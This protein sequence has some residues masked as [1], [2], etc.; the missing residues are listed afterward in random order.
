MLDGG[1]TCFLIGCLEIPCRRAAHHSYHY[2][3]LLGDGHSTGDIT[4]H[5]VTNGTS[6]GIEATILPNLHLDAPIRGHYL[7]CRLRG[8]IVPKLI[9]D[10]VG[11]GANDS[12]GLVLAQRQ[13][14]I[15]LE[16]GDGFQG[17]PPRCSDGQVV[18][19]STGCSF[20]VNVGVFKQS[21]FEFQSQDPFHSCVEGLLTNGSVFY[22]LN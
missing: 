12:D 17:C 19:H 21:H 10:V 20:G 14:A 2:I 15:V 22:C 6:L 9:I 7:Y 4:I 5:R 1:S 16:H 8:G 13:G 18:I 11:I 3:G